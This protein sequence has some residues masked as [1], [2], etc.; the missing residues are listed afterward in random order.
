MSLTLKTPPASLADLMLQSV[1]DQ[2]RRIAELDESPEIAPDDLEHIRALTDAAVEQMDGPISKTRRALLTQT[3]TLTLDCWPS[4]I[5]LPLSPVQSVSSVGYSD[6]DGVQQILDPLA[7]RVTGLASWDPTI[8]LVNGET[9]PE[10][11]TI[12][13]GIEVEFVAG[14]GDDLADLPAPVLQAIRMLTAHWYEQ[15]EAVLTGSIATELPLGVASL[16]QPYRIYR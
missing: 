1:C 5:V 14:Y 10:L 2:L 16:I 4:K 11:D 9:W 15:R 13:A 7:Y 12:P 8:S 3:W 6:T